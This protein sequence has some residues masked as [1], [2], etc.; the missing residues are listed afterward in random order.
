MARPASIG[1]FVTH[2]YDN[3]SKSEYT[4]CEW[5]LNGWFTNTNPYNLVFKKNVIKY[6]DSDFLILPEIHCNANQKLEILNYTVF[7]KNRF[8]VGR[9]GRG[10]GG[11]AIAVKN[12]L[13]NFHKV[14]AI[15]Q[16]G[17]DGLIGLKI[18]NRFN[19]LCIG[20]VGMYLSP[21]NYRYGQDAEGYFND[22][23]VM[24][25][26]FLDCDLIIGAGD[27]NARTKELLDYIPEIDGSLIPNRTNPDKIKNSHGDCFLTFLKENRA[28]ILNGRITPQYNNFTFVSPQRGSSVPDY[29]FCPVDHLEYCTEV[30]TLFSQ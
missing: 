7:Q 2:D 10:S 16:S 22:A 25:E 29:I 9:F 24:W 15:Y 12:D 11:I 21:D 5:N 27:V 19:D 8:K 17:C 28:I 1:T 3:Y 4:I 23:A 13:L 30:K 20:I 26:D 14:L 18:K 6:L